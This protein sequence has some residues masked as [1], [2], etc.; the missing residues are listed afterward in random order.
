MRWTAQ[1]KCVN[2]TGRLISIS[3]QIATEDK[4]IDSRKDLSHSTCFL[5]PS[6]VQ[7]FNISGCSFVFS[8]Q[9]LPPK[10]TIALGNGQE[11]FFHGHVKG[12]STLHTL[13][14]FLVVRDGREMV[15]V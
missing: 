12:I 1:R 10:G 9:M 4:P 6:T 5:G 7:V 14:Q 13:Q 3:K 8:V 15:V 11:E 2:G